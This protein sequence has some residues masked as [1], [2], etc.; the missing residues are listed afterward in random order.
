MSVVVSFG[1]KTAARHF[2]SLIFDNKDAHSN[3]D[4][5][6]DDDVI[7]VVLVMSHRSAED[8][9]VLVIRLDRSID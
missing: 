9:K 8:Q 3:D 4:A 5:A 1:Y 6:S 2:F 7:V